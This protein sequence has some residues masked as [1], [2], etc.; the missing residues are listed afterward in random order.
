[1]AR[2]D[3]HAAVPPRGLLQRGGAVLAAGAILFALVAALVWSNYRSAS[4]VRSQV[5]AQH[6]QAFHLHAVALSHLLASAEEQLAFVA[7]SSEVAA[8]YESRDLGMSM[9]YG[10]GLSLIPIRQR[11]ARLVEG[12][13]AGLP[14]RFT[15]VI[16]LDADGQR[17]AWAGGPAEVP[18]PGPSLHRGDGATQVRLSADGQHLVVVRDHWFKGRPAGR[19]AAW[20]R[21]ERVEAALMGDRHVVESVS[22]LV[23][24]DEAGQ[25]YQPVGDRDGALPEGLAALPVDGPALEASGPGVPSR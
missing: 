17:L 23:V 20:L 12:G 21:P 22:R 5:L 6:R 14:S 2:G 8:F 1:M 18:A 16:L 7:G 25:R 11:L 13:D 4:E 15:R 9:A 19:L 24:L 10:L 3:R